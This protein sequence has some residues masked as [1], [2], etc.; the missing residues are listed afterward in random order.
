MIQGGDPTGKGKGGECI[1]GGTFP[2]EFNEQ[3]RYGLLYYHIIANK[4]QLNV[5]IY[6]LISSFFRH[7]RRGI[8]SMA[9]SE[10]DSN[11]S[12]FFFTYAIQPHLNNKYTIVGKYVR[13][14]A[15]YLTCLVP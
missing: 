9:N 11:G 15:T 14:E 10:P 3:L 6:S 13:A 12:Q 8:L 2:D 7:D 1:W 5:S 4:N